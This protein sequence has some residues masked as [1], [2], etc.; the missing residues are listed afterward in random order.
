MVWLGLGG[1]GR[2]G[3]GEG[4]F[5]LEDGG[6]DELEALL[7]GFRKDWVVGEVELGLGE[8]FLDE[9]EDLGGGDRR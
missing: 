3:L 6:L 4:L 7:V 5:H 1:A 9:S 8:E 2:G